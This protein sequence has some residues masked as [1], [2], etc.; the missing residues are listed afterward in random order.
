MRQTTRAMPVAR[1]RT[2]RRQ[3][4][5]AMAAGLAGSGC[6]FK[7]RGDQRFTFETLHTG[8]AATSAMGAQ[9]R[10][11]VRLTGSARLVDDP[12]QAQARLVIHREMREREIVG[13][14][15]T[16]QPREYQ[17]RL[18]LSFSL[19]GALSDDPVRTLIPESEIVLRRDVSTTDT[20][21][22]AKRQEE[23]LLYQEMQSDIV[24]QLLRRLAA[25]RLT[26]VNR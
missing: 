18:R 24:Q 12:R 8:F 15:T 11:I 2:S 20:Q 25:V 16:G 1:D 9:F 19:L 7:L 4:L 5:L 3:L 10:R 14:S 21:I 17:L 22:V 6:G 26:T 23:E 13:L